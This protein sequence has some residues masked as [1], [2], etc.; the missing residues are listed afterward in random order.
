MTLFLL[1]SFIVPTQIIPLDDP[2]VEVISRLETKGLLQGLPPSLPYT[3]ADIHRSTVEEPEIEASR[4]DIFDVERILAPA[5]DYRFAP[6]LQLTADDGYFNLGGAVRVSYRLPDTLRAGPELRYYGSL[7]PASFY[8][9]HRL[10]YAAGWPDTVF[11]AKSWRGDERPVFAEIPDARLDFAPFDWLRIQAGRCQMQ[12]GPVPD[13]GLMLSSQPWGLDHAA[14]TLKY[15]SVRFMTLF[16]WLQSDKRVVLHRTEVVRPHWKLGLTETVVARDTNDF[17]PYIAAPISFFYF[18]QWNK[19]QDDNIL[20]SVDASVILPPFKLYTEVLI[21]DFAYEPATGPHKVGATVGSEWVDVFSSQVDLRADYTAIT[22]WTYAQRDSVQNYTFRGRILGDDLGPDADRSR[23]TLTW[24]I[25]PRLRLKLTGYY[26][27]H[28]EGDV[29]R[30]FADDG[31]HDRETYHPP[32][33][34]GIIEHHLGAAAVLSFLPIGRSLVAI[35]GGVE[36]VKNAGH[37]L[38]SREMHPLIQTDLYWEF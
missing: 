17:F 5:P 14:Y 26:E 22:K 27:R 33:P 10:T 16:A 28:G 20:W 8:A 29:W 34:S 1:L 15:R 12:V 3:V 21:D 18:M 25:I 31:A 9:T 6:A 35:K 23:L 24:R 4:A 19:R 11:D 37:T 32:F 30:D 36:Q 2:F 38:G 7:G 13:G